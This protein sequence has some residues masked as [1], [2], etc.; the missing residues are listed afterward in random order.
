M[1]PT[2][3]LFCRNYTHECFYQIDL[4]ASLIEIIHDF[5][6]RVPCIQRGNVSRLFA[7]ALAKTLYEIPA[8]LYFSTKENVLH[9]L[10]KRPKSYS[11]NIYQYGASNI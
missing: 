10:D 2:G 4:D 8:S 6:E 7:K 1:K 5:E 9:K 3:I 11:D